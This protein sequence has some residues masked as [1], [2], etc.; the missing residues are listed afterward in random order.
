[1][2]T[3]G[4]LNWLHASVPAPGGKLEKT[5]SSGLRPAHNRGTCAFGSAASSPS[6][7][8]ILEALEFPNGV[9]LWGEGGGRELVN[10]TLA[11]PGFN[12][13][14]TFFFF[15]VR[16]NFK[17]NFPFHTGLY[18]SFYYKP[19][20]NVCV[21]DNMEVSYTLVSLKGGNFCLLSTICF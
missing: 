1:M 5:D 12:S 2:T 15:N 17:S 7:P 16:C 19:M 8:R 14:F 13:L 18:S 10:K 6:C 4:N 20:L 3:T 21:L 11:M 9:P